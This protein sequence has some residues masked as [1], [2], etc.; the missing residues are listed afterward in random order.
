M[1]KLLVLLSAFA[2]IAGC[3]G[4]KTDVTTTVKERKVKKVKSEDYSPAYIYANLPEK[5]EGVEIKFL[6]L[7][8]PWV[9]NCTYYTP[10]R[11]KSSLAKNEGLRWW[12]YQ[13]FWKL[14]MVLKNVSDKPV[15][16]D[17][18]K[19]SL[20]IDGKTY[21]PLYKPA[22]VESYL[23]GGR[24]INWTIKDRKL[25]INPGYTVDLWMVIPVEKRPSRPFTK[26]IDELQIDKLKF[27]K[28]RRYKIPTTKSV[29][30]QRKKFVGC[31]V[32]FV[33]S[34]ERCKRYKEMEDLY[35]HLK[36]TIGNGTL[37]DLNGNYENETGK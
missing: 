5:K 35:L 28:F 20:K 30:I 24:G 8:S 37:I 10:Y 32:P 11:I 7:W 4:T 17:L 26:G 29:A 3:G 19:I 12:S 23:G 15:E 9:N 14:N 31:A 1:R 34:K 22:I 16:V 36:G 13:G 2:V 33:V 25:I 27:D 18:N 6:T 21:V